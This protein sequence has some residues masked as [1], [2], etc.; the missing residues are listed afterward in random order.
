MNNL[1]DSVGPVSGLKVPVK[2]GR[3]RYASVLDLKNHNHMSING[4]DS[5]D[6]VVDTVLRN[7]TSFG[8]LRRLPHLTYKYSMFAEL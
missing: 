4:L 7:R 5:R 3:P 1:V 8:H 6:T 2:S